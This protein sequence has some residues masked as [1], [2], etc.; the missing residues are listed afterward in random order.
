M[1]IGA[2]ELPRVS[3]QLDG[4]YVVSGPVTNIDSVQVSFQT[5]FTNGS[6]LYTLDGSEPSSDSTLYAGPFT[7]TNSVTIRVIAYSADFSQS[8]QAGPI[9]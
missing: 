4:R 2:F 6:L 7:L 9:Q 5:T 8:S 3:I 1:D